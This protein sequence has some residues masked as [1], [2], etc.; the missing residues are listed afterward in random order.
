MFVYIVGSGLAMPSIT[1]MALDIFPRQRGLAASCQGFIQSAGKAAVTAILAPLLWG[2]PRTMAAG[3]VVLLCLGIGAFLFY[4]RL[5]LPGGET[6][7]M[8]RA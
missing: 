5:A 7:P 2:S 3:Q 4:R 1:L 6:T 8:A